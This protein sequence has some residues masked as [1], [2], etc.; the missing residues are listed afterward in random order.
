[1]GHTSSPR[2]ALPLYTIIDIPHCKNRHWPLPVKCG[3]IKG[4]TAQ[5]R[6]RAL[7]VLFPHKSAAKTLKYTK[8]SG[9]FATNL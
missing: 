1:M 9:V 5:L 8:Y 6:L 7:A 4:N 2:R 3:K